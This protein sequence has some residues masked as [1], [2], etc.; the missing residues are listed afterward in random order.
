MDHLISCELFPLINAEE[1]S[2]VTVSYNISCHI[3]WKIPSAMRS[4]N[5]KSLL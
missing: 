1:N 4:I 5:W 3:S 2:Q